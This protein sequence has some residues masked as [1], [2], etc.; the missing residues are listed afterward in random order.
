MSDVCPDPG[1][2]TICLATKCYNPRGSKEKDAWFIPHGNNSCRRIDS[3]AD[4]EILDNHMTADN[5]V[6]AVH[7]PP[8]KANTQFDFS[9]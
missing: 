4:Q 6:F 2:E 9:R 7:M 1:L 8:K 3:V 5:V